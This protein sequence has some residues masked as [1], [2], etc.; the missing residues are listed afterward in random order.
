[1]K[2]RNEVLIHYLQSQSHDTITGNILEITDTPHK[3]VFPSSTHSI[4][5]FSMETTLESNETKFDFVYISKVLE[6]SQRPQR[7]IELLRK[8]SSYGFIE[9]HSPLTEC[10]KMTNNVR[11]DPLSLYILWVSENNTINILP[12]YSFF[13]SISIDPTFSKEMLELLEKYSHYD[14]IYY[15]WSP[16]SPL[17][18]VLYEHGINF[19][20]FTDYPKLLI[21]AIED[22]VKSTNLFLGRINDV[23]ILNKVNDTIP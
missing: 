21:Q 3:K 13:S 11:G 4:P 6:K 2:S 8:R 23:S 22:S 9:A 17:R 7:I 5:W 20:V 12:K 15:T 1:M 18:C 16:Q 19:D 10:L 14:S